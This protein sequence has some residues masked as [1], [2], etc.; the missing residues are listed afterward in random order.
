M[1]KY[2]YIHHFVI[3]WG[4][5]YHMYDLSGD[6]KKNRMKNWGQEDKCNLLL[7]D[8]EWKEKEKEKETK[9]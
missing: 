1:Y 4:S 3:K 9:S 7:G 5:Y 8:Y 2:I 6:G